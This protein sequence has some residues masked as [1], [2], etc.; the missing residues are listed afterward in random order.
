MDDVLGLEVAAARDDDLADLHRAL[1]HR[2]DLDLAPALAL[3][4]AG[5]A[6]A[7]PQLV[8]GRVRDC[9]HVQLRDVA[10]DYLQLHAGNLT[11]AG[12]HRRT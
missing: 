8:V 6:C 3:D 9:V 2:F 4:R 11:T 12:A 1:R 7:H 10:L 5:D